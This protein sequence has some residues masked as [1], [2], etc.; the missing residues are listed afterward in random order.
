MK[1]SPAKAMTVVGIILFL[2]FSSCMQLKKAEVDFRLRNTDRYLVQGDFQKAIDAY[3][4]AYRR[5][6]EDQMILNN[7]IDAIKYIKNT[8]DSS[9]DMEDFAGAEIIYGIL[10]N[11]YQD[12]KGFYSLLPFDREELITRINNSRINVIRSQTQNYIASGDFQKAI[13]ACNVMYTKYPQDK[14]LT[15]SYIETIET[16]KNTAIMAFNKEDF[17]Y[18]GKIYHIL[19]NNFH[20]FTEFASLLSFNTNYLNTRITACSK[21]LF[22]K[23]LEQYRK[24]NLNKAIYLWE[25]L[26]AF[27]PDNADAMKAIDTANTQL[28]NLEKNR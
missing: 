8:A 27:D 21:A 24:G 23:G 16:I 2:F 11:N 5:Y 13:D 9:F 10:F 22:N 19:L 4:G 7:Y 17:V 1:N 18:A 6:P 14:V 26:L 15:R 3:K 25:S 12:F 28:R 20:N